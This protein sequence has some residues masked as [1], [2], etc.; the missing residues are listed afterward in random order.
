M[1]PGI[2]NG[3]P[4]EHYIG[5]PVILHMKKIQLVLLGLWKQL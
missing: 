3:L 2:V 5:T 4:L 1:N